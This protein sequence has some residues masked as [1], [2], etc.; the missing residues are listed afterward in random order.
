M[1][2]IGLWIVAA[3]VVIGAAAFVFRASLAE[4]VMLAGVKRNLA[5]DGVASLGDGLHIVLCGAGGPLPDPV[6]SGPCNAVI[7]AGKLFVVDAGSGAARNLTR[8][9][10]FP[11]QVDALLLTH[12][13]SDHIDGMGELAMLRWTGGT[14]T[15]PLP[16]L[17]PPGVEE[18]V[19]GFDTA[20]RQDHVYRTAHHGEKTAPPSGAGMEARPFA[21]PG[22]S[23]P[24][25]IWD[26]DGLRITAF[27]VDHDPVQPAVGYRFD[28]GGR[29]LLISGDTAKS[30]ELARNAAGVDLLV[31]EALAPHLV[32]IMN[33]AAQE[34]GRENL[35]KITSDIPD[36][37]TSPVEAAEVAQAAGAGHLLLSHIVPPLPF[38]GMEAAFLEGTGDAYDGPITL[39]RDGTQVSL[40]RDSD[41]V[42]VSSR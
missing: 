20:Y 27:R 34:T 6:R 21:S 23:S 30:D 15:E 33:Q 3:V 9:G 32:A 31:H 16:V 36:Y 40:P 41:A 1:R 14:H 18:V 37:H 5:A 39:G 29:S 28:Y 25:I 38:P 24:L 11:G 8:M 17:G 13:H 42:E 12:F 19:E 22:P 26:Q 2:R 4:R 7:A 10:F 35:V